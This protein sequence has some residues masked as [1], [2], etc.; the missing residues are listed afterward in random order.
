MGVNMEPE[1][2]DQKDRSGAIIATACLISSVL[3]VL[4][5]W[6]FLDDPHHR[7]GD[8]A[9]NGLFQI[10][11]VPSA[12]LFSVVIFIASVFGTIPRRVC[13]PAS[14]L[15]FLLAAYSLKRVFPVLLSI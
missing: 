1:P 4:S 13:L 12:L 5:L 2:K 6:L 11:A 8:V 15:L 3:L 10:F 14:I 7:I 9:W